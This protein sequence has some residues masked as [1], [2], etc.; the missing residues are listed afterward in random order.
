MLIRRWAFALL[1][2]AGVAAV[3]VLVARRIPSTFLP[4]ED[5][6][7][8]YA[9]MQL[10]NA[11]SLQRSDAAAR[12]VEDILKRIPGVQGYITVLGFNL[13]SQVQATYNVFF[14]ITLKPWGQRPDVDAIEQQLNRELSALP[15]AQA[16]SFPPPAIPGVGTSGGVTFVLQ[17][18]SGADVKFLA[19]NTDRFLAAARKRPELTGLTTTLLADVPQVFV[20]VDRARVLSQQVN[21][22]DVY[23]AMQAF[24]GGAFVNYFNRFGR[25]WQVYIQAD[26]DY[27]TREQDIGQFYV[28]GAGG[29]RVP[30]SAVTRVGP[31]SGPEFTMR[32]QS[33][34]SAQIIA[35]A[36]PGYSS[37]QARRALEE[38]FAQTMPPEMGYGYLGLSYQE[39]VAEQGVSPRTVFGVAL[40]VVFLILAAQYESWSLPFSVFLTLPIA[41]LGAFLALTMRNMQNA[42]YV[43]IGL[44]MLIGLS[45]KNAILIVEFAKRDYEGGQS[46]DDAALSG[47]R[48]RLRPILMTSLAFIIGTIPL[49]T[50]TGAG[51]A[52]RRILGTT[53]IGGMLAATLLAVFLI[54]AM[55][56]VVEKLSARLNKRREPQ[57]AVA[58]VS[59]DG[60][61]P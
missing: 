56:S 10:P 42:V 16:F 6:G 54:P 9:A 34:R 19:D 5:F 49:A 20:D 14:F 53:V 24:M 15:E 13:L 12:K 41:V 18:R 38:T 22:A 30:L 35:T 4:Q 25:Q 2:I 44:I 32:Y 29:A 23:Q 33:Y 8:A 3:A 21:I 17:D 39:Q 60:S 7:Y 40:L 27:R 55:F 61:A 52:G 46:I 26:G 45:A 36:A 28:T 1:F 48:V 57:S 47:A 37:T 51:S 59:G 31:S 58:K 50:A 43:Q 11:A